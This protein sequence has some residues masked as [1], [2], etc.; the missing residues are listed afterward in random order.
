MPHDP[1]WPA[2]AAL[3]AVRLI[4]AA[5]G[6]LITV[7]HIGSTAIPGILAKPILDLMPVAKSL[8]ALEGARLGIE[9]LGYGWRGEH[10]LPGRRY[11][12][13]DDA[14]TGARRVHL[15]CYEVSDPAVRRHLAFRDHLRA[16]LVLAARYERKKLQC[17]VRYPEDRLAYSTC[18]SA[19]IRE[20]ETA[21][22]QQAT[23]DVR[24]AADAT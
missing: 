24:P 21:A 18:K 1:R 20:V 9:A 15:H 17:A 2:E 13:R 11:C 4:E 10:G 23:R 19:W 7:H 14:E 8:A 22:L 5:A 6:G 12:T 3:E 16:D